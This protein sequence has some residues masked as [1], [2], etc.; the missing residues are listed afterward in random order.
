MNAI[1]Q[2]FATK[3]APIDLVHIIVPAIQ[4]TASQAERKTTVRVKR[5]TNAEQLV[6]LKIKNNRQTNST[7]R[8]PPPS[9][10]SKPGRHPTIRYRNKQVF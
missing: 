9:I 7:L 10:V 5:C 6:L 3:S 2:V 4:A 8:G 1:S